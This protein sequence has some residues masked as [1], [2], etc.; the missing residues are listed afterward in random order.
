MHGTDGQ[1]DGRGV[2][3]A[4]ARE[5]ASD[6]SPGRKRRERSKGLLTSDGVRFTGSVELRAQ[7]KPSEQRCHQVAKAFTGHL[8]ARGGEP[9]QCV[10]QLGAGG[11]H[12][13]FGTII[14]ATELV[15]HRFVQSERS[16]VATLVH[17]ADLRVRV[18]RHHERVN[19]LKSGRVK[20]SVSELLAP[21][22]GVLRR[23]AYGYAW[24]P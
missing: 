21:V 8:T 11:G 10:P 5:I 20:H 3:G 14:R 24:R 18:P 4:P 12:Q 19:G 1:E 2:H 13:L 15:V 16:P 17:V 7:W 6:V 9:S 22:G 23:V